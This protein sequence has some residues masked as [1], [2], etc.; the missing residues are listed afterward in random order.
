VATAV[1]P[2]ACG[3]GTAAASQQRQL[4]LIQ[5]TEYNVLSYVISL[6]LTCIQVC[7][8]ADLHVNIPNS[9]LT[10]HVLAEG[11]A[12]NLHTNGGQFRSIFIPSPP[13][14]VFVVTHLFFL[15]DLVTT[16]SHELLDESR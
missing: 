7:Q 15:T 1:T 8:I 4:Q 2:N 6:L 16:K 11:V 5:C 3:A 13:D 12:T 9:V 14:G 10:N